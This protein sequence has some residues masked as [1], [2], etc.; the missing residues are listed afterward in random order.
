MP[1][2]VNPTIRSYHQRSRHKIAF[3]N[4][5]RDQN[6]FT[7]S[8]NVNTKSKSKQLLKNS[9][10]HNT[11]EIHKFKLEIQIQE[12]EIALTKKTQSSNL[13]KHTHRKTQPYQQKR[14]SIHIHTYIYTKQCISVFVQRESKREREREREYTGSV[15]LNGAHEIGVPE[16][17]VVLAELHLVH[18]LLRS[19]HVRT[20]SLSLSLFLSLASSEC[21][22]QETKP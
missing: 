6:E 5:H 10:I 21:E 9:E 11:I 16:I 7:K 3:K 1:W 2:S 12:I 13:H 15:C 14:N 8:T 20:I 19:R 4:F 18:V 17:P 22:L